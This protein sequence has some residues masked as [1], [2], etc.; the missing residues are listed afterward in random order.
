MIITRARRLEIKMVI[1]GDVPP[2]HADL[3]DDAVL[4][5]IER[6]VVE[7]DVAGRDAE[8]RPGADQ[9]VDHVIAHEI[10]LEWALWLWV[11]EQQNLERAR[12]SR[13]V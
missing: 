11:G 7:H 13:L 4:P 8:R 1:A 5:M 10:D 2:W 3:A 6:Q 12:F 9:R